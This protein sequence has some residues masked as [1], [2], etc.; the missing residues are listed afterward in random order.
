MYPICVKEAHA[1]ITVA[2]APVDKLLGYAMRAEIDADH[3][4]TEMSNRVKNPLLVQK[5]RILAFEEQ[6]HKTVLENLFQAMYPGD[7]P[8]VPEKVDPKLLPAVIIRPSSDLID[9]IRQAMEAEKSSQAFYAGLAK[10]VELAKKKILEYLSKVERSH[11]LMLRSEY[12]MAQ[13]FADYAE[14]DID[15]GVT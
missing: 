3:I 6:K 13:Q 1:M 10:R 7:T 2:R 5:F 12:A 11:Y 4:Y 8:E 15:K 9:I 14:K